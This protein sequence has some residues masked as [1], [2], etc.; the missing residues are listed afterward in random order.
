MTFWQEALRENESFQSVSQKVRCAPRVV[1]TGKA[2]VIG[3]R[4]YGYG[5]DHVRD[6]VKH[7]GETPLASGEIHPTTKGSDRKITAGKDLVFH[8]TRVNIWH[9][10]QLQVKEAGISSHP[11]FLDL[12]D[13]AFSNTLLQKVTN[14]R[15]DHTEILL[16]MAHRDIIGSCSATRITKVWI[17]SNDELI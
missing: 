3:I 17:F 14:I 7:C 8:M 16:A 5:L 12:G 13:F 6:V 15:R 11:T 10:I 4:K 9:F 2:S 1:S